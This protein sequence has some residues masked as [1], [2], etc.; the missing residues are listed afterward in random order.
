MT[1]A[2]FTI[3][4]FTQILAISTLPRTEGFMS[5]SWTSLCLG[6]YFLSFWGLAHM[7]HKG[8]PLSLLVPMLA[9][10]VPLATIAIGVIF[11]K[12][13]ASLLKILMLSLA[14]GLIG[15]ASAAK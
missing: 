7:I 13:S 1:L 12:E 10:L 8:L 15:A 5:F 4:L 11:Y 9:A 2:I 3:V 14:C 6:L